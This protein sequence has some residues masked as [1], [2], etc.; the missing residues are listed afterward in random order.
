MLKG[1]RGAVGLARSGEAGQKWQKTPKIVGFFGQSR[2]AT[3]GEA[4]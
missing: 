4:T 1:V 2:V 3:I